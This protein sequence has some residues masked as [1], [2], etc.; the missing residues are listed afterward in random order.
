MMDKIKILVLGIV[1]AVLASVSLSS[2]AFA[3]QNPGAGYS[4][5]SGLNGAN[6]F[7]IYLK[8]GE[9]LKYDI[10]PVYPA[11]SVEKIS[12]EVNGTNGE[13]RLDSLPVGSTAGTHMVWSSPTATSDGVWRVTVNAKDNHRSV[14]KWSIGAHD[15]SN[16][17]MS[18]RVWSESY[19][20]GQQK[21]LDVDLWYVDNSG[22]TYKV[23][24]KDYHGYGSIF[25]ANSIGVSADNSCEPAYQSAHSPKLPNLDNEFVGRVNPSCKASTFRIFFDSPSSD[26]PESAE[27]WDGKVMTIAPSIKSTKITDLKFTYN[28]QP[29][30]LTGDINFNIKNYYSTIRILV[31]TNNNGLFSDSVDRTI[32]KSIQKEGPQSIPFDGKD[33]N[34]NQININQTIRIQ[35]VADR[36]GEIHFVSSDVEHRG[37][38]IEIQR[39]NG[40]NSDRSI[41]FFDDSNLSKRRCN[42]PNYNLAV[43]PNGISSVGGVHEWSETSGTP[44]TYVS[45]DYTTNPW[46]D[47]R[48]IDD[49]TW[50]TGVVDKST[51]YTYNPP[52]FPNQTPAAPNTGSLRA[53]RFVSW[54]AIF[55]AAGVGWM[56]L[57][58]RK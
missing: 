54:L 35:V 23:A 10:E 30:S 44:C 51:I 15:S 36:K 22:Y 43:V 46:G 39:L 45:G 37:G 24:F 26:L 6:V 19:G 1:V 48:A 8:K 53:G 42:A 4:G 50:D 40:S 29:D 57:R 14:L 33:G 52:A 49:W 28:G 21:S 20:H 25:Q 7:Y 41:V 2:A 55:S 12:L 13:H 3:E 17:L 56:I 32:M 27:T 58:Q 34:G 16:S 9:H 47:N 18:G 38:G 5:Y 11:T 31:D